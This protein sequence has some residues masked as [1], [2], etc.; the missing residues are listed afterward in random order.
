MH[1]S[2]MIF[3]DI[4][5]IMKNQTFSKLAVQH[6]HPFTCK[7]LSYGEESRFELCAFISHSPLTL[8][9]TTKDSKC[10]FQ[11]NKYT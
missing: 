8:V 10:L 4:M 3:R 5:K 6:P 7:R 2:K 9:S 11:L 1:T